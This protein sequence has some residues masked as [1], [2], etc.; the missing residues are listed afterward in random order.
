MAIYSQL[1]WPESKK[2]TRSKLVT[3]LTFDSCKEDAHKVSSQANEIVQGSPI[4]F[5][6]SLR[7]VSL[8]IAK[9]KP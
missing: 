3:S 4:P 8:V 1:N 6:G 2:N 9:G 7:Q 5:N